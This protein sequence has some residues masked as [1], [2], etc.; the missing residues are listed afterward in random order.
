MTDAGL[1]DERDL[2]TPPDTYAADTI[3]QVSV[4]N[5]EQKRNAEIKM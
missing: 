2:S 1:E 3:G 5:L 4:E